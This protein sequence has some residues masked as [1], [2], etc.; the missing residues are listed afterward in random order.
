M[1]AQSDL[2]RLG[3]SGPPYDCTAVGASVRVGSCW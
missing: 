3:D 2:D 1:D